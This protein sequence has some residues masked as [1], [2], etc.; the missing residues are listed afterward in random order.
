MVD[1]SDTS[2]AAVQRAFS[3]ASLEIGYFYPTSTGLDK[4]IFDA[5]E[6]LCEF[7]KLFQ[8]HDFSKQEKGQSFKRVIESR[9][10]T[11]LDEVSLQL[12]LYR[13]DSK[14]GDPRFWISGIKKFAQP[15]DL[16]VFFFKDG[17]LY[18]VNSSD[19]NLI[20]NGKLTPAFLSILQKKMIEPKVLN[21]D[22]TMNQDEASINFPKGLVE[23]AGHHSGG[24]KRLF[25]I[26][27][28]RPGKDLLKTNLIIRLEKWVS[29]VVTN[30]SHVPRILFLVGGPGNGKTEAI[31]NTIKKFDVE[32][33]A[34][35]EMVKQLA[36]DFRPASG[37]PVPRVVTFLGREM[38]SLDPNFRL[39]I[40]QD[41]TATVTG[42][43]SSA[44]SLLVEEISELLNSDTSHYY[45]CCINRG[46]LDEALIETIDAGNAV[47]SNLIEEITK[48]VSL[49]SSAP[50][51]WPLK[52]YPTIAVWPMDVESLFIPTDNELN[53]VASSLFRHAVNPSYWTPFGTC[54][55]GEQCPFC[56]SQTIL[57]KEQ[58]AES[59]LKILRWYELQSGKRWSFRD[60]F[61]LI[62]YLLAG[63]RQETKGRQSN[64]C[65]W[66]SSLVKLD[67]SQKTQATPTKQE[68]TA[69]FYLAT[70]G[71]QHALF[72]HWDSSLSNEFKSA[73]KEL[74]IEKTAEEGRLLMGFQLFMS[75]KK[76]AYLP[77]TI[78]SLL[79]SISESL[80]PAMANPECEI[81]LN[82]RKKINLSELDARFSK[83]VQGGYD[84][85]KTSRLLSFT[86]VELLKRLAKADTFLSDSVNRR[87]KPTAANFIQ[88]CLRDFSCRLV[89]RSICVRYAVVADLN[90]LNSFQEIVEDV[91]GHNLHA[92]SKQVRELLNEKDGFY[93][94]LT[95]TFGQPLPPT[96]RQTTLIVPHRNVRPLPLSNLGRPTSPICYLK[97]GT[98]ESAQAIPLTYDLFRAIKQ[99]ERGMSPAS[100]SRNV[101][102]LLDSI[103]ARLSGPIVR[104]HELWEDA[105]IQVGADGNE[106]SKSFNGFV[107]LARIS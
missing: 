107:S 71:Y 17:V 27:S 47:V 61:S 73:L 98:G 19:F 88:R 57:S 72:H 32:F 67:L 87:K 37:Q 91:N 59:L 43:K 45:L 85:I 1:K 52:Q 18:L 48:V 50:Q 86:E 69:I 106:I 53:S 34:N 4:S 7:F 49:S 46:V 30:E 100:L 13:P 102:A 66:A 41:A 89:R 51:C 14:K 8:I 38:H 64:P 20:C 2:I 96:Q 105:K 11:P 3:E 90:V 35:G 56:N 82:V 104:D 26:S 44:A 40:V 21:E 97:I 58:P 101:V 24:V 12:S 39:D 55:A 65:E 70:S 36:K 74:G 22:I 93:V 78:S 92:I 5:H 33:K 68:L 99:L 80:D 81:S 15:N 77:A 28:G 16:L 10:L 42:K 76:T 79:T 25:D 31:E 63:Y 62:S 83:S 29:S 6:K 94:S 60:L 75:D 84:F 103:K 54:A 9:I 95:T 23:W